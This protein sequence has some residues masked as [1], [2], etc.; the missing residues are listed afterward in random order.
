MF[1]TVTYGVVYKSFLGVHVWHIFKHCPCPTVRDCCPVSSLFRIGSG[2]FLFRFI[3]HRIWVCSL[4]KLD[5]YIQKFRFRICT[6]D[7]WILSLIT[8]SVDIPKSP[9][10]IVIERRVDFFI[11]SYSKYFTHA[12]KNRSWFFSSLSLK[13]RVFIFQWEVFLCYPPIEIR[14][15]EQSHFNF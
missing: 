3:L 11:L 15:S 6:S 5:W 9:L 14:Y 10:N 7:T 1:C 8:P 13:R 4:W 12:L 2:S